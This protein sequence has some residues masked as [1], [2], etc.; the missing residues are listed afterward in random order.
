MSQ[1]FMDSI[2]KNHKSPLLLTLEQ[3]DH[4]NNEAIKI[5]NGASEQLLLTRHDLHG[6]MRSLIR[7]CIDPDLLKERE[8]AK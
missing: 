5:C 6:I 7:N 4:M 3:A 2:F 1:E 8:M